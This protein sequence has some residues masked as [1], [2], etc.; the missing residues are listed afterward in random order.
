M[1]SVLRRALL[2]ACLA[3]AAALL[4]VAAPAG[5]AT[6]PS[7]SV[8][9]VRDGSRLAC[10][11]TIV[12]PR[13]AITAAHCL[14]SGGKQIATS[15]LQVVERKAGKESFRRVVT[16][17]QA[18]RQGGS[19]PDV[20]LLQLGVD[21]RLT[22]ATLPTAT[23]FSLARAKTR[24]AAGWASTK[25]LR[26]RSWSAAT[27]GCGVTLKSIQ[28]CIRFPKGVP[29][30]ACAAGAGAP[31][32]TK[33]GSDYTLRAVTGRGPRGCAKRASLPATRIEGAVR[34]WIL[35]TIAPAAQ[36]PSQSG[37][38]AQPGQP[39]QPGQPTQPGGTT[40]Q[41]GTPGAPA[42][43]LAA[44]VGRWS[45]PIAQ[46]GPYASNYS[47]TISIT[48][49]GAVGTVV[50]TSTYSELGCGGNLTYAGTNADGSISVTETLTTGKQTC[51][52]GGTIKLAAVSGA[53]AIS[54][55]WS[56]RP[57]V[58]TSTGQLARQG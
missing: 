11:A 29:A 44:F 12:A 2:L 50:G 14:R 26:T 52:D 48:R 15:R 8:A 38:P 23:A 37:A 54:Y 6:S 25:T 19:R 46:D 39:G 55:G 42:D 43:A 13:F 30:R 5:A 49:T 47:A 10:T 16:I 3:T 51:I 20:A 32:M 22:R 27:G 58:G 17:V 28:T 45:G 9:Q 56:G 40:P 24:S 18:P 7:A 41:P 35:D 36:A 33:T 34:T 21:T 31:L 57:E 1:N 53:A 4:G